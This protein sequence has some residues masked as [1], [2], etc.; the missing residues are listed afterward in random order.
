LAVRLHPITQ[1][2]LFAFAIRLL[3]DAVLSVG[4]A[5]LLGDPRFSVLGVH[6]EVTPIKIRLVSSQMAELA[7]TFMYLAGAVWIETLS[8]WAGTLKA[9]RL[10]RDEA[11]G[12]AS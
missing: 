7:Q 6:P 3:A 1:L 5:D 10:R 8:R 11:S 2:L 4:V 12:I 9:A